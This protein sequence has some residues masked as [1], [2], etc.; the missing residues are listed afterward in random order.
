MCYVSLYFHWPLIGFLHIPFCLG[1]F[2]FPLIGLAQLFVGIPFTL[3]SVKRDNNYA[4]LTQYALRS[5]GQPENLKPE[6]TLF[7]L[8]APAFIH[9][10]LYSLTEKGPLCTF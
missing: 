5:S 7:M 3:K 8:L 1:Q 4:H 2:R 9:S 10:L 6:S